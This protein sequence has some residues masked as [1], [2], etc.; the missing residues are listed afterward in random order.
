MSKWT[1]EITQ[2]LTQ[3]NVTFSQLKDTLNIIEPVQFSIALVP[4]D[5]T[6]NTEADTIIHE[7]IWNSKK[8]IVI[9]RISSKLGFT[10]KIH[11]RSTVIKNITK[12][13]LEEFLTKNHINVPVNTKYKYG[14]YFKEQLVAVAAFSKP[15]KYYRNGHTYQSYELVRYCSLLNHTVIGGLSKL[16]K[17][18]IK[19]ANPDDIVTYID[20][21]WSA[22]KSF[23]KYGFKL[24]EE[25]PVQT[26]YVNPTTFERSYV[27]T[28]KHTK[29][30]IN[31]GNLKLML[32]LKHG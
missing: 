24:I 13:V 14:L 19:T 21:E 3:E 10:K 20:K 7:D 11:G 1:D 27:L 28:E 9:S 32:D 17:H 4:L 15:R 31:K 23:I 30:V 12:P 26:F 5:Q 2:F 29:P 16:L 6:C 18:F 8:D 22:G 25:T